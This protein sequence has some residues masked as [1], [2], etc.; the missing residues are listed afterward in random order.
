MT[1][2]NEEKQWFE[3]GVFKYFNFSEEEIAKFTISPNASAVVRKEEKNRLNAQHVTG[4]C[5][6]CKFTGRV[7]YGKPS[8][9]VRHLLVRTINQVK[10]DKLI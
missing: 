3:L 1:T 4:K 6:F 2:Q 7:V 9:W 8:N 5:K 10:L